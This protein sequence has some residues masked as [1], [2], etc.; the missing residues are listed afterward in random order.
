MSRELRI[1]KAEVW[2]SQK[3]ILFKQAVISH[4][5][6]RMFPKLPFRTIKRFKK[7]KK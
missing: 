5:N 4:T 2:E 7:K 1:T 6:L 3:E